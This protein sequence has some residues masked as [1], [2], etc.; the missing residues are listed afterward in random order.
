M[1]FLLEKLLLEL[2]FRLPSLLLWMCMTN[3][4]QGGRLLTLQLLLP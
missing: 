2:Q 4:W 3:Y 1:M